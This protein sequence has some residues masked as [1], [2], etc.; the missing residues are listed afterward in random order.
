MRAR[1]TIRNNYFNRKTWE[2]LV[3][4]HY[5]CGRSLYNLLHKTDLLTKRRQIVQLVKKKNQLGCWLTVT[6]DFQLLFQNKSLAKLST[7]FRL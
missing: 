3:N 7:L 5:E 1:D 2:M 4:L 6:Y